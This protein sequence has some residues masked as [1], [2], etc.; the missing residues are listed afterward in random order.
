MSNYARL[1]RVRVC[2]SSGSTSQCVKSSK[3]GGAYAAV[4]TDMDEAPV[5][6]C[7]GT[8]RLIFAYKWTVSGFNN[9]KKIIVGGDVTTNAVCRTG[10][11]PISIYAKN[12]LGTADREGRES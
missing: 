8:L 1:I 7:T 11:R 10:Q 5:V 2:S 3:A 6:P 4:S 9:S 12:R